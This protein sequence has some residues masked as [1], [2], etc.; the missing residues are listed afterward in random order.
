M[1]AATRSNSCGLYSYTSS[2][3]TSCQTG[4]MMLVFSSTSR[5]NT[6]LNSRF[7]QPLFAT[8]CL[9]MTTMGGA[10]LSAPRARG[11]SESMPT[12]PRGR[13]YLGGGKETLKAI[14]M[15]ASV[16]IL[17]AS[18]REFIFEMAETL[19]IERSAAAD[20]LQPSLLSRRSGTQDAALGGP[21]GLT[22]RIVRN[23]EFPKPTAARL[24]CACRR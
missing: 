18:E 24:V 9:E 11:H 19:G 4:R 22:F 1:L 6:E 15:L 5:V 7:V 8:N 17:R 12:P 21:I 16:G 3:E 13:D 10:L 2:G 14:R 20:L 23:A